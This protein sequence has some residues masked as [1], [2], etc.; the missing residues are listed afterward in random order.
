MTL[1]KTQR[2]VDFCAIQAP[3]MGPMAG[4]SSGAS[5]YMPT[6][7]PRLSAFHMSARTPPPTESGALPPSPEMKRKAMSSP[8]FCAKPQARLK[9]ERG[10]RGRY[11]GRADGRTEENQVGKLQ[12][13]RA[14]VDLA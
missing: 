3:A 12:D 2:Q 14:A 10:V 13:S 5:E 8:L 1:Q 7:R 6:A 9:T 4:P 11:E